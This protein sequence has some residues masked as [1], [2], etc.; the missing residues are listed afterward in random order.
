MSNASS[1]RGLPDY[2]N[3]TSFPLWTY[4]EL[5]MRMEHVSLMGVVARVDYDAG[6]AR[7]LVSRRSLTEWLPWLTPD[8]GAD[9]EWKPIDIGTTVMVVSPSGNPNNGFILPASNK[10]K[11]PHEGSSPDVTKK[12]W[13]VRKRKPTDA[14]PVEDT[15]AAI[16]AL[17]AQLEEEP[18]IA[19]IGVR[20]AATPLM[21]RVMQFNRRT[22][23][24]RDRVSDNGQ[25]S[26]EVHDFARIVMDKDKIELRVTDGQNGSSITKLVITKD[27]IAFYVQGQK[28]SFVMNGTMAAL[29]V[30]D[31]T[32]EQEWNG[33]DERVATRV[34]KGSKMTDVRQTVKAFEVNVEGN[35]VFRL[36]KDKVSLEL[37][38]QKA[39]L[40]LG[41]SFAGMR[42]GNSQL[43]LTKVG[44]VLQG[45][46][47][48]PGSALSLMSD[49]ATLKSALVLTNKSRH[50]G[51]ATAAEPYVTGPFPETAFD[52]LTVPQ[53][54]VTI[55][56][57]VSGNAPYLPSN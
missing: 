26:W 15:E 9:V 28:A 17:A 11:V 53:P 56:P 10:R 41:E 52:P 5:I 30:N 3:P 37:R 40:S 50:T 29:R 48:V 55:D 38:E 23:Q 51:T 54:T 2:L 57:F 43:A 25:F 22:A 12:I 42:L 8:A 44:G 36:E 6:K 47:S 35:G 4:A 33:R 49:K 27:D 13:R 32:V 31:Q 45:A 16:A 39:I 7:V 34:G 20:Y 46:Y 18:E 14:D 21:T 19:D 24:H 1:G